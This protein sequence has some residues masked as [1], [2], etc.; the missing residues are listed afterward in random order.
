M[1]QAWKEILGKLYYERLHKIG[2]ESF[3]SIP[4]NPRNEFFFFGGGEIRWLTITTEQSSKPF[5]TPVAPQ[6]QLILNIA[7]SITVTQ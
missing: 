3:P 4:G 5:L 1:K 7:K 6:R 2:I